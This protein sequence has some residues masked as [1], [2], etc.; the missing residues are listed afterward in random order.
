VRDRIRP[1]KEHDELLNQLREEGIF[2]T[3]QKAI[4]F[5]ASLGYTISIDEKI[6]SLEGVGEGI[7]Y[8][9]FERA[10]DTG[11][12]DAL[13]VTFEDSLQVLSEDSGNR[14]FE[15]F[16]HFARIGLDKI[17][18]YCFESGRDA[19]LGILDLID[20]YHK[21][22]ASPE[23]LPGLEVSLKKLGKLF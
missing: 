10:S 21:D 8:Q 17:Q 22:S 13:A 9:I 4:M 14:R 5:A 15:I 2:A 19:F 18:K 16:E 20:Q 12:I 1:S 3:R 23:T 6:E 7:P 11:F